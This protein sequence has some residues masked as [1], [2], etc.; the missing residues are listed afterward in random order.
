M[1]EVLQLIG[2]S[3]VSCANE[4]CGTLGRLIIDPATKSVTDL[5]VEP[6]GIRGTGRLVSIEHVEE[7][8]DTIHLSCS[9]ADFGSFNAADESHVMPTYTPRGGLPF[10]YVAFHQVPDGEVEVGGAE[11]IRATD[12]PL[13]HLRGLEIDAKDHRV[14]QL[15]LSI[16]HFS[17]KRSDSVPVALVT[18]IGAEGITLSITKSQ[19][20]DFH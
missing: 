8:D 14:T 11:D 15:I 20:G 5:A 7:T 1:P 18:A 16:G 12:G 2:G 17:G 6:M 9:R 4:V 19:V 13:G 3:T 10:D